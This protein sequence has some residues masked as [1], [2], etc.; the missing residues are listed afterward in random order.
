[1]RYKGRVPAPLKNL[2]QRLIDC[3]TWD[4]W[5]NRSWSQEGEDMVLRRIFDNKEK[6]F[7]VDVGA[8]HPKR[9][10]NTYLFYRRG[11]S[12]INVDAMP[13]SMDLFEKWRPRDINLEVGVAQ[14]TGTLGYYV[15]NEPALNGFSAE[16][17]QERDQG[18]SSYRI[19]EVINI[20]VQPLADI[21]ATHLNDIEIDFLT[22]DVEGLDL[23]V[24]KS[25]DWSKYRP[26]YVLAE[27]L[28]CDPERLNE[29]PIGQFMQD[30][31]YGFYAKQMNTLFFR[32][33]KI[34]IP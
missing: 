1:M 22:V 26:K 19:K 20:K 16:L 5:A 2:I 13:G 9:F 17:S 21:L 31:Q 23:E 8:H 14:M 29:S 4:P 25:N 34:D 18:D 30:I 6:G 33:E 12:G 27:I 10:S 7:Y 3:L 15:F 28:N 32:D 11:W 24:L